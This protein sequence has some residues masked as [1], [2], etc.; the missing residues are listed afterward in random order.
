MLIWDQI[1][2]L[3]DWF[4]PTAAKAERSER[5]LAQNF[6]FTHLFGPLLSQSIALFLY[7]SDPH[8]GVCV[9]DGDHLHMVVLDAAVRLQADCQSCNCRRLFQS[10]CSPSPRCSEPIITAE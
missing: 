3:I 9:L 8:P 6:V 5:G 4:I 1:V 7:L 2:A 10:N